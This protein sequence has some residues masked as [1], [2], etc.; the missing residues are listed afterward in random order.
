MFSL[1]LFFFTFI[2]FTPDIITFTDNTTIVDNQF[3]HIA[4]VPLTGTLINNTFFTLLR[5]KDDDINEN[6]LRDLKLQYLTFNFTDNNIEYNPTLSTNQMAIYDLDENSTRFNIEIN[7][8]DGVNLINNKTL[9]HSRIRGTNF[10]YTI[11]Y[12]IDNSRFYKGP[13]Q[14]FIGTD[15]IR[16]NN[17]KFLRIIVDYSIGNEIVSDAISLVFIFIVIFGAILAICCVA[18]CLYSFSFCGIASAGHL[19]ITSI[20]R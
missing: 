8:Y 15:V 3:S 1:A 12:N 11:Y 7:A 9:G 19:I 17:T 13:L 18:A 20:R 4:I 14:Y 5:R 6:N 16:Y 2:T 10:T